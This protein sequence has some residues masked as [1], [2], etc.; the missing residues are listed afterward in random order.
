MLDSGL[1]R[2]RVWAINPGV[3]GTGPRN[4]NGGGDAAFPMPFPKRNTIC[5]KR[6]SGYLL[7]TYR[8]ETRALLLTAKIHGGGELV[9]IK[10]GLSL[11]LVIFF[12]NP[13]TRVTTT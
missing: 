8:I 10:Y 9:I 7:N 3:N 5:C 13:Q 1:T 12:Q 4:T 11:V 2:S 6:G